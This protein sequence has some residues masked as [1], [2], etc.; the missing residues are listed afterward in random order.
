MNTIEKLMGSNAS[1]VW[2]ISPEDSVFD[3]IK[4]NE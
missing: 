3:A 2:T 4:K 1:E